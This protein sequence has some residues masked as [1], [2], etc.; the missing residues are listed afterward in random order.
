MALTIKKASE[1][2]Q[3][4]GILNMIIYG[5]PGIGKTTFGSTAPKPLIIDMEGGILS[6]SDSNVDIAQVSTRDEISEAIIY[7]IKNG[8]KTLVFDSL[9]HYSE[10]LM[11]DILKKDRKSRPQIQHWGTLIDTIKKTVWRLQAKKINTIFICLEKEDKDDDQILKRPDLPGSL[12]AAV[13]AIVDIVGYMRVSHKNK[14]MLSVVPTDKWY[15]KDRSGKLGAEVEPN[16]I[17][18]QETIFGTQ[19]NDEHIEPPENDEFDNPAE[20]TEACKRIYT[21][22]GKDFGFDEEDVKRY[23]AETNENFKDSL[24]DLSLAELRKLYKHIGNNPDEV[25]NT[26]SKLQMESA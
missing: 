19:Q 11:D 20:V 1:I 17:Q 4:G 2:T 7:G 13:P 18:I 14:R 15:A 10:I 25:K 3:D 9:T 24:K 16:F 5:P 23:V 26:L 22:A 8:Y 21:M 12:K 6:I